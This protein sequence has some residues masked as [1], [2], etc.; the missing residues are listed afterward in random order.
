MGIKRRSKIRRETGGK[1]SIT[2]PGQFNYEARHK[3]P[4]LIGE[5]TKVWTR[6][7]EKY[8]DL[9]DTVDYDV[10][11]G[12]GTETPEDWLESSKLYWTKMTSKRIDVVGWKN[13]FATILEVK[14]RVGLHTLGQILGY[15][16][17]YHR[18]HPTIPL[19]P[20]IVVCSRIDQDD[21]GILNHYEVKFF[22]V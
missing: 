19:T 14:N 13:G 5:D 15:R 4:H 21:I 9:F 7:I 2:M 18:E 20:A 17:L 12:S 16:F 3:Y 6:F 11:V 10:H 22:V 8:P 1:T